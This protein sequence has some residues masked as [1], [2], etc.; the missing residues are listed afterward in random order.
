LKNSL[1]AIMSGQTLAQIPVNLS[2]RP[3]NLSLSDYVAISDLF[4]QELNQSHHD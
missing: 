2:E 3:E 4:A 1:K